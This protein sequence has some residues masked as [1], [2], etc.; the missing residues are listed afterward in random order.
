MN[1][2]FTDST[3]KESSVNSGNQQTRKQIRSHSPSLSLCS[4]TPTGQRLIAINLLIN[5]LN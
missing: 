5:D 1:R 3:R 2:V 4:T